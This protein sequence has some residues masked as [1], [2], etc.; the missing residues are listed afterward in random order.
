MLARNLSA[1]TNRRSHREG[2]ERG[3]RDIILDEPRAA[4]T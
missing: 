4:S 1:E 3:T 2:A